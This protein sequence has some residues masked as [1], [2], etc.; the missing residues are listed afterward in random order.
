MA[1]QTLTL[2]IASNLQKAGF[3]E[4]A[5]HMRKLQE[6]VDGTSKK[7]SMLLEIAGKLVKVFTLTAAVE[8]YREAAAE[9]GKA[10]EAQSRLKTSVESTGA[11][12]GKYEASINASN[13][14]LSQ[15][16]RF[17][18]GD[19]DGALNILIQR[20]NSVSVAQA[21][22][23]TVMGISAKT[24]R[25]LADV[26]D[27]VGR[28]A[29]GSARDTMQLAKEFGI[30]GENAKNA[31]Y[32]LNSLHKTFANS[33]TTEE[34]Y[35]K[36]TA[37]MGNAWSDLKETV[38]KI[39]MPLTMMI[40]DLT[41]RTI[42]FATRA[43]SA[44][45]ELAKGLY[46]LAT[47]DFK[48]AMS[49]LGDGLLNGFVSVGA[50]LEKDLPASM[51]KGG[52]KTTAAAHALRDE[53]L[54]MTRTTEA[55]AAKIMADLGHTALEQARIDGEQQKAEI[56]K[57]ADFRILNAMDQARVL[58]AIEKDTAAKEMAIQEEKTQAMYGRYVNYASAIGAATGNLVNGQ[59]DA[60]KQ[61]L[62]V[63]IDSLTQELTAVLVT[64]QAE[65]I[66]K[67][68]AAGGWYGFISGAAQAAGIA[69]MGAAAKAALRG[70]SSSFSASGSGGGGGG[71]YSGGGSSTGTSSAAQAAPATTPLSLHITVQGDMVNDPA[72]IDRMVRKI[73][74]SV[75][76][77][78]T[79]LVATK[80]GG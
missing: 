76:N 65:R 62:N 73:S 61:I 34:S 60:W 21:N 69:A 14:A 11:S 53:L 59:Q 72:F 23:Q 49:T 38:G 40:E 20:T 79:R 25:D 46:Q 48:K 74:D 5:E 70:G 3:T 55:E 7:S 64:S 32:V 50:F 15:A 19:L 28:A 39:F 9:A 22:L 68:V 37:K 54:A 12:W 47:G 71:G 30:A 80:V 58:L 45:G 2:T 77:R 1:G 13:A 44:L 4:A 10:E 33:A 18:K 36:S 67:E 57:R 63:V 51:E 27:Q 35:T 17:A 66:A 31:D 75:E 41:T 56:K 6:E 78:N 52:A 26:S 8:F 43:A 16:S 29:N 42:R 24:G